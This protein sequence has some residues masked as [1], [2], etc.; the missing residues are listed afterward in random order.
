MALPTG[1][2]VTPKKLELFAR[3][4][5]ETGN[6]RRAATASTLALSTLYAYRHKDAAFAALWD[7]ALNAAMDIVL[8]PEAVRRAVEGVQT[9]VFYRGKKIADVREYSDTLLMFLLNGGKPYKYARH[10]IEHGGL[11]G[12][13]LTIQV[14][15]Y[16]GDPVTHAE[17]PDSPSLPSAQLPAAT[18][19]RQGNGHD[20]LPDRVAP[21]KR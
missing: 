12:K 19:Y 2:S 4:L 6:V 16:A 1:K 7:Q 5:A 21:E 13:P 17:L 10:R 11:D 3:A 20:A 15:H 18:V 9:P 8:E 14:I